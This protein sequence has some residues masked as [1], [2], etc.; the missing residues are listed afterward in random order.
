MIYKNIDI[1]VIGGDM[2]EQEI[3][4]TIED[5]ISRHVDKAFK[6]LTITIIE[7]HLAELSYTYDSVGIERIRRVTGYLVGTLDLFNNAKRT[8][9][10]DRVKHSLT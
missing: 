5:L 9:E 7:D 8:E 2:S 3:V 1:Q 4:A 6:T 10:R